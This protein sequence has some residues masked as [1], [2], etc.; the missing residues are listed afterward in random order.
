MIDNPHK[1]L[2]VTE[3]ASKDEIKK[4]YR[5]MARKY[6]PDMNPDNPEAA[7]KMNE[8]N[9]AY[10]ILMD[11][12]KYNAWKMQKER[13]SY[14]GNGGGS[15]YGGGTG[16][17]YGG[18]TGA[19]GNGG[20][21]TYWGD[22]EDLF[23]GNFWSNQT[24]HRPQA[25]PGDSSNVQNAIQAMNSGQYSTAAVILNSIEQSYRNARWY[26]L[27]A[28]ANHGAGN[29]MLATD[30]IQKAVQMEPNNTLYR[31]I[32]QQYKGPGR[33]YEQHSGDFN[34]RAVSLDKICCGLCLTKL[35]CPYC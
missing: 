31:Q 22:F 2:G 26:Y 29:T 6:H 4:A 23:G 8:I 28:I 11:D 32:L 25:Q 19:Y 14:Y 12:S 13:Q 5:K 24:Q 20:G 17:A 7:K 10:D 21:Y 15:Y 35:L 9:E 33:T 30:Y 34:T 27:A 18:G 1:I 3:G 16:S